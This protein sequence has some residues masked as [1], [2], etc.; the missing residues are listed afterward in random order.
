MATLYNE[1]L[2]HIKGSY[3]FDTFLDVHL[4]FLLRVIMAG[5]PKQLGPIIRSPVAIR[6][7]LQISLLERLMSSDKPSSVY[8]RDSKSGQYDSKYVTKLLKNFRSH[9][10]IL[11]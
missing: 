6:G 2:D 11:R 10:S 3:H 1:Q 5:D 8:Q 4:I 7:G 9:G